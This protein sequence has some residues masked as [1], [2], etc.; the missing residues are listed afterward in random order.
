MR[1]LRA[2][3]RYLD[4]DLGAPARTCKLL[5]EVLEKKVGDDHADIIGPLIGEAENLLST[6]R[7]LGEYVDLL[8]TVPRRVT[9]ELEELIERALEDET[10]EMSSTAAAGIRLVVDGS[11]ITTALEELLRNARRFAP[12]ARILI[13]A[14]ESDVEVAIHVTDDGPGIDPSYHEAIFELGRQLHPKESSSGS[15]L[16]L[17]MCRF[18]A[19]VHGG[20]VTIDSSPGRG[21]RFT[22]R[23][24]KHFPHESRT[25]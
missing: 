6:T 1:S 10:A 20:D 9:H 15:G 2:L 21:S 22:I 4:H 3:R 23:I 17:G 16:G 24:P 7:R 25:P 19:E 12:G 14:E 13:G 18:V 11:M 8:S 5:A